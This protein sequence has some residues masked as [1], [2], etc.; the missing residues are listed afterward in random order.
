MNKSLAGKFLSNA[1]RELSQEAH[2]I[3]GD[4]T[5]NKS[6]CLAR[7]VWDA[8]LGYVC[9]TLDKETGERKEKVIPP[10]TWAINLIF[11]RIEGKVVPSDDGSRQDTPMATR[12]EKINKNQFNV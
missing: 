9:V 2:D 3:D 11:D 8:A 1:L 4:H 10:Q 5:K 7:Y 6:E 12:L